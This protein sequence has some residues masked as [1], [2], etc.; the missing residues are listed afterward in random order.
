MTQLPS[1]PQ[2]QTHVQMAIRYGIL[3]YFAG[4]LC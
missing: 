2:S 3:L 1:E 4:R